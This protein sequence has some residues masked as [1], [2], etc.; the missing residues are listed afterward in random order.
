MCVCDK[1]SK[2]FKQ[3]DPQAG[4]VCLGGNALAADSVSNGYMTG[5][6]GDSF[7]T[8]GLV[9]E[10]FS[11]V[12]AHASLCVCVQQFCLCTPPA[13]HGADIRPHSP[14]W[15]DEASWRHSLNAECVALSPVP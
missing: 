1:Y 9:W 12:S 4:G 5:N 11:Q 7:S 6:V 2:I 10:G 3:Q 15:Q 8:H 14:P 13:T